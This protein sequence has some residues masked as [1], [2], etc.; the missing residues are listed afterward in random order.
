MRGHDAPSITHPPQSPKAP[1]AETKLGQRHTPHGTAHTT[2]TAPPS[3]QKGISSLFSFDTHPT[4]HALLYADRDHALLLSPDGVITVHE[5]IDRVG[6]GAVGHI[7]LGYRTALDAVRALRSDPPGIVAIVMEAN[8]LLRVAGIPAH[9]T[10]DRVRRSLLTWDGQTRIPA[11]AQD[12]AR[13]DFTPRVAPASAL[14]QGTAQHSA[15]PPIVPAMR[16]DTAS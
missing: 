15:R 3:H 9:T 12:P 14:T 1:L 16:R 2:S 6:R 7:R 5:S 4:P 10:V 8:R 13:A 11:T